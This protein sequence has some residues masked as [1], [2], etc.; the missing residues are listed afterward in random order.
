MLTH[1]PRAHERSRLLGVATALGITL[2]LV[3]SVGAGPATATATA[4]STPP[5]AAAKA[6]KTHITRA[7][8][9][10]ARAVVYIRERRTAR[11]AMALG[12]VRRH[13]WLA[14][15][16]A[17]SLIGAPPT[18]PESDDP[19]GPP[20]IIAALSLDNRIITGSVRE[21][22]KT[23][24]YQLVIQLSLTLRAAQGWQNAT[25]NRVI[26]L[27]PE[28]AGDDYADSMSDTLPVY[29]RQVKTISSALATFH[30]GPNG[31]AGLRQALATAKAT[32]AKVNR[33]FGGG[34][35]SA[36]PAS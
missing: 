26:A 13:T 35:R 25:L 16:H 15:V 36:H 24:K 30:L 19:P 1:K 29:A 17:M 20:A 28:G 23:T 18:D 3:A 2:T 34:E 14:N 6:A 12:S 9:A 8:A 7:D 5:A 4:D 21:F 22:S 32:Q 11:A 31:T 10:L 27:P 33:A